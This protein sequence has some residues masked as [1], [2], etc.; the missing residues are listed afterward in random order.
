[1][2][3]TVPTLTGRTL[4]R[5]A[6]GGGFVLLLT[7][8]VSTWVLYRQVEDHALER[9]ALQALERAR[10][11]E[12]VLAQ[13][14]ESHEVV[15]RAFVE[16]WPHYQG[17]DTLRRFDQL[18]MRY[19]DGAI[20]NRPEISDGRKWSTGWIRKGEVV[21]DDLKRRFVLFF[22]LSQQYGPGMVVREDNLFFTGLPEQANLGYDPILYPDWIRTI[23]PDFDQK[24]YAW[25][26]AAY[27]SA[28]PGEG[29]RWAG[30]EYDDSGGN[31][32]VVFSTLTPILYQDRHL[33]TVCTT[34][35]VSG[36]V[37]RILPGHQDGSAPAERYV[38]LSDQGMFIHDTQ[39]RDLRPGEVVT[40]SLYRTILAAVG[41][42]SRLPR[43]T[44]NKE[45]D[46]YVAVARV[47][48][49]GWLMATVLPGRVVRAEALGQSQWALWAGALALVLLLTVFAA[50]LRRRIAQP[51]GELTRAAERV[52]GG[53]ADV[54]LPAGRPDELGRLAQA[55]NDMAAKVAQRD[56]ALR[57]DKADI[58][59]A[60]AEVR[61]TEERWRAMT[62]NASDM[63]V[64]MDPEGAIRY[65]SPSVERFLGRPAASL[66]GHP[67][68][69]LVHPEDQ[70]R[71]APLIT[72]PTGQAVEFR[73]RRADGE[74][75]SLESVASDLRGHPAVGGQ[76][77]NIRDITDQLQAEAELARQRDALHQSEKLA[78]LGGLLAGVAHE[79]NNPLAVVVGRSCQLEGSLADAGQRDT[80]GAIRRAAERC[81]RIVKTFLAMA[82]QQPPRREAT[83]LNAVILG[84]LEMLSYS[85]RSGGVEVR[86][87][88]QPGLPPVQADA[89]Q[90][91]QVFLNLFTN[92]QHALAEVDGLRQLTVASSWEAETSRIRVRV[93]DSGPGIP[94]DL[95]S[96]IFEPFFTTKGVGEGTGVGLA[97][98]LGIVQSHGGSLELVQTPV[99][100]G[101]CFEVSLPVAAGD[102][103]A[104]EAQTLP[105]PVAG[106]LRILVVDDEVEIAE[107][108]RDILAP[109][110]HA[111]SLAHD[112]RQA[113][114]QLARGDYDLVFSDLKMPDMDGP[115]LY[116]EIAARHP[117]LAK[118]VVIV[119]GDTLG[120]A[121][122][123]FL[124]DTGLPVVDKPFT[125]AAIL[126][127]AA[128]FSS[129]PLG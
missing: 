10:V 116:R 78:A 58:E 50:V 125:P 23:P 86:T 113:L 97:V 57:Q 21:S 87:R 54:R 60:L 124:D 41:D 85:L 19:P 79:L 123:R 107:I 28:Q 105:Q 44:F 64:V 127:M 39:G 93:E 5:L 59:A 82:R 61:R 20:R 81:A 43:A 92:A 119:T 1:M 83:D 84:A 103:S 51:L 53:E 29:T 129:S 122:R 75:R 15:R 30:P 6:L 69:E 8:A 80:A 55:F 2:T 98:S 47:E 95:R 46:S 38:L 16:K 73:A 40:A 115:A 4:I 14:V 117:G 128:R 9:L 65:A 49:P 52:A 56:A 11:T 91:G 68:L 13:T 34:N 22:D 104:A 66:L 27:A 32:G 45:V 18:F 25:G 114:E 31:P 12:R 48:G 42:A 3:L 72:Q 71:L 35:T 17:E 74:W 111:V 70:A 99:G 96:R 90:L 110:G 76:V 102:A 109:A 118:R 36:T 33:A 108:L 89:D 62:E 37:K 88:L 77:L 67:A 126:E 24:I 7:S 106:G 26:R 94:P 101:A 63:I 112:G 120:G 121:A 100:Q